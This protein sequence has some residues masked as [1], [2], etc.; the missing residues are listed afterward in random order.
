MYC[1]TIPHI[2]LLLLHVCYMGPSPDVG[3]HPYHKTRSYWPYHWARSLFYFFTCTF[4]PL[5]ESTSP[6]TP[7]VLNQAKVQIIIHEASRC[8]S[9]LRD[10]LLSSTEWCE[11]FLF[12]EECLLFFLPLFF[13]LSTAG[14]EN[15]PW[16]SMAVVGALEGR[17]YVHLAL[18]LMILVFVKATCM[19]AQSGLPYYLFLFLI[20]L[21]EQNVFGGDIQERHCVTP[22]WGLTYFFI[23]FFPKNRK[24]LFLRNWHTQ[25]NERY[26]ML[27]RS[28]PI[29]SFVYLLM[30]L[31]F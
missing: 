16:I 13:L 27:C 15:Q 14:E 6:L 30:V 10:G 3:N 8:A 2:L 5:D 29:E 21:L 7:R 12:L 17:R 4:K 31:Q 23:I 18:L 9:S 1:D 28:L 20:S 22:Q 24:P 26:D 25:L 19:R 11:V